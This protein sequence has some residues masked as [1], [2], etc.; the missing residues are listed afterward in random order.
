MK[1][2]IF[3]CVGLVV[4]SFAAWGILR[5]TA[6]KGS[7]QQKQTKPKPLVVTQE[8]SP[9]EYFQV[10]IDLTGSVEATRVARLASPA[11]GPINDCKVRE[12]DQVKEG[13]R[14]LGHWKENGYRSVVTICQARGE[15]R[16]RG[17]GQNT[18]IG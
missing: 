3:I 6:S 13:Q 5:V 7:G 9:G 15:D 14:V 17:I 1:R 2:W 12:G 18:A 11:E 8:V 10:A 16:R 4:L